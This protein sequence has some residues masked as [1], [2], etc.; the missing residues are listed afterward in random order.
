MDNRKINITANL[1]LLRQANHLTIEEVADKVD[2]SLPDI[3]NCAAIAR[4]YYIPVDALLF[5]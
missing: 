3:I 1:R 5:Q 4:L 2:I